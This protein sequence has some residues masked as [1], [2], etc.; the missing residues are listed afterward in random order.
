MK[1]RRALFVVEL[2]KD[3]APHLAVLR[4][5]AP[6]LEHLLVVAE[7][8]TPAFAWLFGEPAPDPDDGTTAS[9]EALR[10]AT[11]GAASSI[12][13]KL[14]PELGGEALAA[15]C[16]AER[17]DL[18]AFG[19]RSLRSAWV[20][21]AERKR[22]HAA[23][24]WPDEKPATGPIREIAC[25]ALDGHARAAIGAFLR[26]HA[27]PSMHV[28][29]LSPTALMPDVVATE[30]QVLGIEGTVEV[31][32][33]QD[34]PSV[35][36]WLDEWT[37]ERPVDLLV[38]SRISTAV[39]L[40]ALRAAPVL[41]LPPPSVVRPFGQRAIDVPDLLDDGG[42]IRARVDLVVAVGNLAP[43]PDQAVAFV[44][45]GHV[46][47]TVATR[48]G[49]AELSP[50]LV[51]GSLGVY[52]IGESAPAE[53]VAA[54]EEWVAVI[55]P[56]ERPLVVVDSELTDETLRALA[57]ITGPSATEVLAVRL[58]PTRSCR[59]IRERLR[60]LGLS[61]R[62]L[63]ARLV[64]DEGEALDVSEM[65]DPVRLARVASKLR[66]ARFPVTAIVHRGQ[67][68]PFVDAF[69]VLT[70]A[71]LEAKS[72]VLLAA[73]PAP[74]VAPASAPGNRIELELDNAT[75]RGWLLQAIARSTKTLH[76]QVYMALDDDVGGPVEAALAAAGAR[77]VAVKVLV[78]SLHGLYRSFGARNPLLERLSARPGVEL[79][80]LRPI[81]V[82]PSLA[83]L[84]QRDHR[85]LV[86]ADGQIALL[87]GRNLSHEYY[88]GF[89]E[90]QITP[91]S[92]WRQVP[93][94]DAGARVEGPIVE[95]LESSFLETWI[96]AGGSPFEIVPPSPVGTSAARVVVH[97]G[98]RDVRTLETYLELIDTAKSH[99]FAVNGFPL[100]LELQHAFLRALRRGVRVRTLIGCVT[101]TYG[102]QPFSGPWAT[103][104]TAA[105]ELV[106]SRM[107]PVIAAGGESYVFAR[108]DVPGWAPELGVV[109]PHVHAKAMSADGLRC[110]VGSAN[111][112]ITASYWES[113]LM[114]VIEDAALA[115]AFEA[116]I[117][118]LMA[119]ST[120]VRRD[121][122]AW[123][124][125]AER[126][127]WMRHWPGVLSV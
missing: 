82:L 40:S 2:G 110:A 101:P 83:D 98:L 118:T 17:I 37:R 50:G 80:A 63:D 107:D 111:M 39:L 48:A 115:R 60:A 34:A 49:E 53:P 103:A 22:Q 96:G 25:V 15:L 30:L 72:S 127:A 86:V 71:D 61:P 11:A 84:K 44:S 97:R 1:Y 10:E 54:I 52:R 108:H 28:T 100:V 78:D 126:R 109:H 64:L 19:S 79:R 32:S 51:V 31:S 121:D 20:V 122:A 106:H 35:Q 120:L 27:D 47:T 58:R 73:P 59:S 42:P 99:V 56:G 105:T 38:F 41:L 70:A 92:P 119:G 113:E 24:L 16:V 102:G 68:E 89:D 93:W 33:L 75:A 21:S 45:G 87:G 69:A 90:V 55:G 112:D 114:L 74:A 6:Q 43:V 12:E 9:L 67:V 36:Q 26:D 88:T 77:G 104:R 116:K 66:S 3:A 125:L 65:L 29:L 123:K 124:Q 8:P 46:V 4:R 117:D 13:V 62:V 94:L 85:K 14:A 95:A 81:T 23:V 5:V 7:L 76:F 18:V 57:E 91:A